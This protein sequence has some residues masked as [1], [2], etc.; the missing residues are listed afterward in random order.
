MQCIHL[1]HVAWLL[2]KFK[3][4]HYC[5]DHLKGYFITSYNDFC[6]NVFQV[7]KMFKLRKSLSQAWMLGDCLSFLN[8]G[9]SL[10]M[11]CRLTFV[12]SICNCTGI[13]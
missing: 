9:I 2:L 10:Y 12:I 5:F 11:L 4:V 8:T 3:P 6:F 1:S 7:Q 13:E